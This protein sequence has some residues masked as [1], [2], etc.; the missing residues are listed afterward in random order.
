[1]CETLWCRVASVWFFVTQGLL[2]VVCLYY[3]RTMK[4]P[5][6]LM[7]EDCSLCYYSLSDPDECCPACGGKPWKDPYPNRKDLKAINDKIQKEKRNT[8]IVKAFAVL[9]IVGVSVVLYL[10]AIAQDW[11]HLEA[12][13][14]SAIVCGAG[15][16]A[17]RST[18][19]GHWRDLWL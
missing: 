5:I 1:M 4:K 6:P 16:L 9:F 3:L 18:M 10:T 8:I 12:A 17:L 13:L 2:L 7:C 19:K 14:A 15:F 11:T